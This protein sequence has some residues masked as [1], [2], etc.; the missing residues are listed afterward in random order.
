MLFSEKFSESCTRQRRSS[1]E[2]ILGKILGPLIFC[3]CTSC[4]SEQAQRQQM[5]PVTHEDVQPSE[6]EQNT[7]QTKVQK[8][9]DSLL[10]QKLCSAKRGF[11]V[12]VDKPNDFPGQYRVI[13]Y[14]T[15]QEAEYSIVIGIR[16]G[17]Q[18]I[19]IDI[20]NQLESKINYHLLEA[21]GNSCKRLKR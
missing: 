17:S 11:S 14:H 21:H 5:F 20:Q 2:R 8:I 1:K 16:F 10:V 18:N 4:S 12:Y 19:P 13:V 15:C 7:I 9:C 3:L 6:I